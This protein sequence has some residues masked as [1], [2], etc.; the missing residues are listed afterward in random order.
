VE[1]SIVGA[2]VNERTSRME[3]GIAKIEARVEKLLIS[4]KDGLKYPTR[5]FLTVRIQCSSTIPACC[6]LE[7]AQTVSQL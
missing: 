3:T 7:V 6:A 5:I 1:T 4:S 2:Q